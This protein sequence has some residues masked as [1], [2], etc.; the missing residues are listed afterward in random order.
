MDT[1]HPLRLTGD[2]LGKAYRLSKST[3][4]VLHNARITVTTDRTHANGENCWAYS[5]DVASF[6]F[7]AAIHLAT[8]SDLTMSYQPLHDSTHTCGLIGAH[9]HWQGG[10]GQVALIRP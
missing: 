2:D 3:R 8:G 5:N 4:A 1:A 6:Y 10:T 7:L 9:V